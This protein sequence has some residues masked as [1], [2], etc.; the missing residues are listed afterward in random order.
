MLNPEID[1]KNIFTR[2]LGFKKNITIFVSMCERMSGVI[3]RKTSNEK[4]EE[5]K[6]EEDEGEEIRQMGLTSSHKLWEVSGG[7]RRA[8]TNCG[9]LAE[10]YDEPPQIVGS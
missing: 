9:K 4:P 2:I 7:V 6:S 5:E 10:G 3:R 8:S 1:K